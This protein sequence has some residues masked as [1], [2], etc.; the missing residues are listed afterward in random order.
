M[1]LRSA[2]PRL[3]IVTDDAVLSREDVLRVARRV[4]AAGGADIAFHLR[5]PNTGGAR[6]YELAV[7]LRDAA[8]AAGALFLVNDR[9]DVALSVDARGVHLGRRSLPIA[10]ARW[11]LGPRA[12]FGVSTHTVAEVRTAATDGADFAFVGTVYQT[13]THPGRK[14]EGPELLASARQIATDLS[15]LAIGGVSVERTPEVL[16]AGADGVAVIRGIWSERDPEAAVKR[17]LEML[18]AGPPARGEGRK[19]GP[20]GRTPEEGD[21]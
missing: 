7:A 12:T 3:H 2:I 6:L 13:P 18:E 19:V 16:A 10:A 14:G 21:R 9:V 15:L 17:Y 1:E 8:E 4:L 11:I 20:G 5:G